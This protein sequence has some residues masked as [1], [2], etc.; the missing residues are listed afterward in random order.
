MQAEVPFETREHKKASIML[1]LLSLVVLSVWRV[2][3]V[4]RKHTPLFSSLVKRFATSSIWVV[5][6]FLT[7]G[8]DVANKTLCPWAHKPTTW[9]RGRFSCANSLPQVVS[10]TGNTWTGE[11]GSKE[12][13]ATCQRSKTMKCE[14]N[15]NAFQGHSSSKSFSD[16]WTSPGPSRPLYKQW[17]DHVFGRCPCC[18]NR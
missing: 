11:L 6:S 3:S 9:A 2:N 8:S 7:S 1:F 18:P 5:A 17:M 10:N 16:T 14:M 12:N 13:E 4:S 15:A